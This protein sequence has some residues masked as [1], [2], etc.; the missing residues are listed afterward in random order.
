MDINAYQ[1]LLKELEP[2][3]A[4][5][6][7]V[8]KNQGIGAIMELYQ[9]GQRMFGE[10]KVQELMGKQAQLPH[11]IAWHMI[12]HLQRNKVRFVAP[13]TTLI[14]GVD[15]QRLFDELARQAVRQERKVEILLQVHIAT[16]E[17][18]FG[19]SEV[20]LQAFFEGITLAEW[21]NVVIRGLMGMASNTADQAQVYREFKGLHALYER[22]GRDFFAGIG[23]FSILS[24][25]MSGDYRIALDAGS[26]MVR[27]G[28]RLFGPR[29]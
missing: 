17:S 5:L 8:S 23:G 9:A 6:I 11:D 3:G 15:S 14:Q 28:S 4:D 25:G 7:A 21:G 16:E 2:Y 13:C 19:F 24:M 29:G 12:G 1:E 27:V 18:K 22:M 20:E 26:N 10:N